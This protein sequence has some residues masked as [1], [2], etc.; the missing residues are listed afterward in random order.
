MRR[1]FYIAATIVVGLIVTIILV[2]V[3]E[4]A[5][6]QPPMRDKTQQAEAVELSSTPIQTPVEITATEP[7]PEP[8][9]IAGRA[10]SENTPPLL[11]SVPLDTRTQWQIYEL[12]ENDNSLFAAAM[13]IANQESSFDPG[14][15]G[16]GGRSVGMMRIQFRF[17]VDRIERLGVTDLTDP[18]QNAAVGIDYIKELC[19]E[20]NIRPDSHILYVA[21][22]YGPS[23]A[24]AL[25]SK[26][27]YSTS[28]SW[29][30]VTLH[31]QYLNEIEHG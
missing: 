14:V 3:R 25:F 9:I 13:A 1:C 5:K 4:I 30:A 16:D 27:I 28:Y 8:E 20:F 18:V 21:Y 31:D 2:S 12:C 24:R 7:T 23:G 10:F 29:N 22:T 26:G 17:H 19:R 15:T 6:H 11:E